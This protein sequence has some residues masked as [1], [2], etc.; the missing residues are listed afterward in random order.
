MP[1]KELFKEELEFVFDFKKNVKPVHQRKNSSQFDTYNSV[2]ASESRS[3][4]NSTF[5]E[6]HPHALRFSMKNLQSIRNKTNDD[7]M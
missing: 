5:T 4:S 2:Q 6:H 1:F 7:D 3:R